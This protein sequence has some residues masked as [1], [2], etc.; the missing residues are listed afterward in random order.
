MGIYVDPGNKTVYFHQ[1]NERVDSSPGRNPSRQKSSAGDEVFSIFRRVRSDDGR[2]G[3]PL[4]YAL[5]GKDGFTI[6]RKEVGKFIPDLDVS[7]GGLLP[8]VNIDGVMAAPSSHKIA[9]ILAKRISKAANLPLLSCGFVKKSNGLVASELFHKM[10]A[11]GMDKKQRVTVRR[12][13]RILNKNPRAD[14]AM[15]NLSVADRFH[16]EPIQWDGSVQF[17]VNLSILLVDDLLA[18]GQSMGVMKRQLLQLGT[19]RVQCVCL[20]GSLDRYVKL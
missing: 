13:I 14:F 20:L 3:N 4:I 9:S 2:D 10:N 11:G 6:S 17:P 7:I 8:H 18:S 19:P 16:V 15:K 5:K 12:I 1:S